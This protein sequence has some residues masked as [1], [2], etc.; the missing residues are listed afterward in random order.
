M[1]SSFIQFE[2]VSLKFRV[3]RNPNP[4]LK[5]SV[6]NWLH[7][8]RSQDSV[9]E[10]YGLEDINLRI[11]AGERVGILGLNGAGKST[12]LKAIVGIYK[13]GQGRVRI[14]GEVVPLIELGTGFDMEL[15]GRE[16]IHL[17]GAL[18]GKKPVELALIEQSIL[19]FADLEDFADVAIKYYSS[20]ML[21]RLAF[22]IATMLE[23]EILLIDEVFSTGD[24]SFISK[25]VN[26]IHQLMEKAQIVV[27]TAHNTDLLLSCCNRILVMHKGS[28]INDGEPHAMVRFYNEQILAPIANNDLATASLAATN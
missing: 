5:E 13:P 18:L 8:R 1:N 28:V 22:A 21:G 11:D 15:S 19:D 14:R 17:N 2:N 10:F 23:S 16:N 3:Y 7:R 25:S 6:V 27:L 12:F 24:A 26:R 20:G 9:L 4:A